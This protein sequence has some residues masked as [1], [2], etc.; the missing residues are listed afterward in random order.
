[1]DVGCRCWLASAIG[2]RYRDIL[3]EVMYCKIV[4]G[5]VDDDDD[6]DDTL[7]LWFCGLRCDLRRT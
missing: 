4:K 2:F 7:E 6:D 3:V 5:L 1:M